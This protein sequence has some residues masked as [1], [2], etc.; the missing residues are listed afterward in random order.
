VKLVAVLVWQLLHWTP[1]AGM[2]GG[3]VLPVAVVPLW[4]LTQFV[5]LGE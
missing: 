4:Q 5:S 1:V 3:V 2:C